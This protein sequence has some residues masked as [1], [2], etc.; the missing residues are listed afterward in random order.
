MCKKKA[1]PAPG[2]AKA[3]TRVECLTEKKEDFCL[4]S[5]KA[6]APHVFLSL[7]KSEGKVNLAASAKFIDNNY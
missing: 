7:V 3:A 5:C 1:K 6:E 4:I 2:A